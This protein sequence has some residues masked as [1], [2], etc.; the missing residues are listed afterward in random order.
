MGAKLFNYELRIGSSDA[1]SPLQTAK[2]KL[3]AHRSSR[4]NY[5]LPTFN[6]AFHKSMKINV[7]KKCSYL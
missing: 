2:Q 7:I 3:K 1:K 5:R 4:K 6:Y